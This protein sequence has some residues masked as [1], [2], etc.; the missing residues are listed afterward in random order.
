[1]QLKEIDKQRYS[2]HFKQLFIGASVVMLSIALVVSQLLIMLT[3]NPEGSNFALNAAGAVTAA[4]V[5]GYLVRHYRHHPWMYEL[6]YVWQLKQELNRIYRKQKAIKAA[7]QEG[8]RTAMII[9]NFSYKGS[10]QLYQLDNNTIT[11]DELNNA[12]TVLNNLIEEHQFTIELADYRP[13]L[14]EQ[15]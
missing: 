8:N 9:M 6:M 10:K 4:V 5:A 13:E 1:M 11:M 3:G 2:K 12:M 14:L 7:M 15:F